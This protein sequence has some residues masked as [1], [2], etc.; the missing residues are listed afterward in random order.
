LFASWGKLLFSGGVTQ[1]A[2][3]IGVDRPDAHNFLYDKVNLYTEFSNL[4][5]KFLKEYKVF[6]ALFL[7]SFAFVTIVRALGIV[8]LTVVRGSQLWA[9]TFFYAQIVAVFLMMYLFSGISR[10]RAPLEPILMLYATVG[11][12][13]LTGIVRHRRLKSSTDSD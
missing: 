1:I 5:K 8:G 11:M 4:M 12:S 13:Y 9:L 3:Y 10:F 7:I 6:L 2:S